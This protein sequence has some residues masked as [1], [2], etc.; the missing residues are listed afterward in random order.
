[1]NDGYSFK[2]VFKETSDKSD[3]LKTMNKYNSFG[4]N[5]IMYT[6]DSIIYKVAEPFVLP[7]SDTSQMLDSLN[8][9]FYFGKAHVEI[10]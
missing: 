10:K 6:D 1:M 9:Y 5:V 7:L 8:K 4:R 2:I 3:A